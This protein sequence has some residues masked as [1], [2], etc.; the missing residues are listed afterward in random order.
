MR[1]F[2][3]ITCLGS[4]THR[5]S[6]PI[7]VR[8]KEKTGK[9]HPSSLHIPSRERAGLHLQAFGHAHKPIQPLASSECFGI[10][11]YFIPLSFLPKFPD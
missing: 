7:L 5:T 3:K 6:S 9:L 10:T 1:S 4:V 2:Y 11:P 8:E